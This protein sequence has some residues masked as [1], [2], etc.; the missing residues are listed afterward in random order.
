MAAKSGDSQQ[1]ELLLT[2]FPDADLNSLYKGKS[3]QDAMLSV[4]PKDDLPFKNKQPDYKAVIDILLQHDLSTASLAECYQRCSKQ[5]SIFKFFQRS[6][7]LKEEFLSIFAA[8]SGSELTN[9][10]DA[11]LCSACNI[12]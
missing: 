12:M 2:R 6:N 9:I 1:L 11:D 8:K 7:P 5:K 10:E 4:S 3:V